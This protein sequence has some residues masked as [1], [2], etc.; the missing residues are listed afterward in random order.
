[1]M[2]IDIETS[3]LDP[4][5]LLYYT[6]YSYAERDTQIFH[7]TGVNVLEFMFEKAKKYNIDFKTPRQNTIEEIIKQREFRAFYA[8]FSIEDLCVLG[9]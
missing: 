4:Q 1:M 2:T 5:F 6:I 9:Y 8:L 3:N 7:E